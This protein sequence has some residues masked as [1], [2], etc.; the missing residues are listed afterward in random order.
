MLLIQV[1]T[2]A[3]VFCAVCIVATGVR[4]ALR[5]LIIRTWYW[6]DLAH[7][8][9]LILFIAEAAAATGALGVV[10]AAADKTNHDPQ[11]YRPYLQL[12]I[13]FSILTWS[14]FYA[15]KIA[16]L[17]FY[18]LLFKKQKWFLRG[19]WAVLV[20]TILSYWAAVAGSLVS[21]GG[22]AAYALNERK[23]KSFVILHD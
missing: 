18:R 22:S 10:Y 19:W 12:N 21:C 11:K 3:W 9:A 14:C 15:V 20:F 5:G 1:Q 17:L 16:F 4:Y 2:V 6:D 13:A 7:G 8:I 23:F